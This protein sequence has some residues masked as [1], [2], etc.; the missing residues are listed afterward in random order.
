MKAT[1][2]TFALLITLYIAMVNGQDCIPSNGAITY[3]LYF[4]NS[5]TGV[6]KD[7]DVEV[8]VD[9]EAD[10]PCR[11]RGYSAEIYIDVAGESKPLWEVDKAAFGIVGVDDSENDIDEC[12]PVSSIL[13]IIGKCSFTGTCH[14]FG[15]GS[16]VKNSLT[17][18]VTGE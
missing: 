16:R 10:L 12:G 4:T 11:G 6:Q 15:S 17:L 14:M 2:I 1:A 7:P 3:I 8:G 13:K 5:F 18:T 9:E